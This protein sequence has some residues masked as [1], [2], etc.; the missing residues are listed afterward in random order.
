M[1]LTV[2]TY[3]LKQLLTIMGFDKLM[4]KLTTS[5]AFTAA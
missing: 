1:A 5:M 4:R 2:L 3:H